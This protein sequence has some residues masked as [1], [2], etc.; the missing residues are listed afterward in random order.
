MIN[1]NTDQSVQKAP[2]GQQG[3]PSRPDEGAAL[4]AIS[5]IRP[6]NHF[7]STRM[8][9]WRLYRYVKGMYFAI[10]YAL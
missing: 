2:H 10:G 7:H 4:P 5:A 3:G 9:G 8:R 1:G 6:P